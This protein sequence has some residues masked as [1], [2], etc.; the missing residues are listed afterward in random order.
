MSHPKPAAQK[1]QLASALKRNLSR[2][3]RGGTTSAEGEVESPS[4]DRGQAAGVNEAIRPS[5]PLA[6]DAALHR[7]DRSPR[8]EQL[9]SA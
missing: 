7:E 5:K 2:R 4:G 8:G 3:K 9:K 1:A 6:R